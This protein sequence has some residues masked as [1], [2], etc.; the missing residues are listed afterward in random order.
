MSYK[1]FGGFFGG[2]LYV[3]LMNGIGT[4]MILIFLHLF[5]A[6]YQR[7]KRAVTAQNWP[8]GGKQLTQ[9]RRIIGTNLLLGLSVVL[10]A[11]GG[12]YVLT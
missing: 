4:L 12:R 1:L 9:I 7:L 3:D 11:S 10:I 8:E 5:F 2:P 6:P